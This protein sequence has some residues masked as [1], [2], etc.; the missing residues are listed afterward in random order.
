MTLTLTWY[1]GELGGTERRC[2][3]VYG[4]QNL[5]L[6]L[7]FISVEKKE[8]GTFLVSISDDSHLNA[9]W[10]RNRRCWM[11]ISPS[12]WRAGPGDHR[13]HLAAYSRLGGS[14]GQLE[15]RQVHW[16]PDCRDGEPVSVHLQETQQVQQR[17][18]GEGIVIHSCKHHQLLWYMFD[19]YECKK[20][21]K[22]S[23]L[24][25]SV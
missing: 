20:N 6:F 4:R 10:E 15:G 17:T 7:C 14:L 12:L 8:D 22:N 19:F 21:K 24:C 9:L 11:K 13:D 3:F 2:H 18:Q 23:N 25:V 1:E 16:T 5:M